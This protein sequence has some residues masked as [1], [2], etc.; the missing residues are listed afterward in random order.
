MP[1]PTID[2]GSLL[3][4]VSEG[5]RVRRLRRT[6]TFDKI[7]FPCGAAQHLR[8]DDHRS[9]AWQ[10]RLFPIARFRYTQRPSFCVRALL[11]PTEG[12]SVL[13]AETLFNP[14][15]REE[16]SS[17]KTPPLP[18]QHTKSRPES[19]IRSALSF[20]LLLFRFLVHF[21]Q[22]LEVVR[23]LLIQIVVQPVRVQERRV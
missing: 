4:F 16:H 19:S 8:R 17:A 9:S 6:E 11:V 10:K 5:C 14:T 7:L 23:R 2:R 12:L 21:L 15:F 20:Y 18:R 22:V 3:C 1:Y 13:C